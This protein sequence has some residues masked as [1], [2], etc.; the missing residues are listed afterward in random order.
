MQVLPGTGASVAVQ[1]VSKGR[2][3]LTHGTTCAFGS[4][5]LV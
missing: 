5:N 2:Q 3:V 1:V 4:A